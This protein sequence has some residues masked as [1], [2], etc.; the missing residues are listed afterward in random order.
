MAR[1]T[2]RW[3]TIVEKHLSGLYGPVTATVCDC[4][5]TAVV[6]DGVQLSVYKHHHQTLN[7]RAR[8]STLRLSNHS[9]HARRAQ[10]KF[11]AALWSRML[12]CITLLRTRHTQ[13]RASFLSTTT[14]S[15]SVTMRSAS[16]VDETVEAACTGDSH[17]AQTPVSAISRGWICKI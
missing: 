6:P 12:S 8:L 2:S 13:Y 15:P 4:M 3:Y 16:T 10:N 17:G 5:V 7:V 1:P 9:V 11:V 14:L